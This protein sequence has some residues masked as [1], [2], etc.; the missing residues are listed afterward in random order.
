MLY[1]LSKNCLSHPARLARAEHSFPLFSSARWFHLAQTELCDFCLYHNISSGLLHH[2]DADARTILAFFR[3]WAS[4]AE[5]ASGRAPSCFPSPASPRGMVS[6]TFYHDADVLLPPGAPALKKQ[7]SKFSLRSFRTRT[8]TGAN[9]T[10]S[11]PTH[12]PSPPSSTTSSL[13]GV[14][15]SP[16]RLQRARAPASPLLGPDSYF[17]SVPSSPLPL[18]EKVR[19]G[20]KGKAAQLLGEEVVPS[21]KAARIL[22]MEKR[23]SKYAVRSGRTSYDLSDESDEGSG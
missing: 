17:S 5:N 15:P 6:Q 18:D 13:T 21:G 9:S 11:T 1:S 20:V 2:C 10:P 23:S 3:A 12:L 8:N 22:G 19:G 16:N 7:A 14:M 4:F